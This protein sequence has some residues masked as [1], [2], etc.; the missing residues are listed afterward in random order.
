MSASKLRLLQSIFKFYLGKQL[1]NWPIIWVFQ[2]N[3][4]EFELICSSHD[5]MMHETNWGHAHLRIFCRGDRA[6]EFI[7]ER[8]RAWFGNGASTAS[9]M[10]TSIF[11]LT[12]KDWLDEVLEFEPARAHINRPL[13]LFYRLTSSGL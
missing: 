5:A 6:G 9:C 4:F 12:R 10:K 8:F 2:R 3:R 11:F 13:V 1:I 7:W